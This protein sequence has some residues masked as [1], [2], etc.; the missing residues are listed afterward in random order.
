MD[1]D[2]DARLRGL[3]IVAAQTRRAQAVATIV[4][5]FTIP[6]TIVGALWLIYVVSSGRV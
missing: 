1:F 4:L 2:L 3:Q 6:A 5:S